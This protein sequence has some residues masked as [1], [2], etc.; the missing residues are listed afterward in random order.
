MKDTYQLPK[1]ITAIAIDDEPHVLEDLQAEIARQVPRL[2]LLKTFTN[3]RA[4]RRYLERHHVDVIICDVEFGFGNAVRTDGLRL[5]RDLATRHFF[6]F[7]SGHPEY[8]R[9]SLGLHA[10]GFLMK[11]L[12]A[13]ELNVKVDK[14]EN[15]RRNGGV[16][17]D[18]LAKLHVIDAET[19]ATE[20]VLLKDI[21]RLVTDPKLVNRSRVVTAK[22]DIPTRK[23][24][25]TLKKE[26]I[27][28][29]LFIVLSHSV[30]VA[31]VAIQRIEG[32]LVHL[33]DGFC[34]VCSRRHLPALHEFTKGAAVGNRTVSAK[35]AAV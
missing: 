27:G 22:K 24:L 10:D 14:L 20:V 30:V 19:T 8:A 1:K 32:N 26:V 34:T 31:K 29:G 3:G 12:S 7:L 21:V 6:L 33:T 28:S 17:Y 15:L 2:Q 9:L 23:P 4:A 5:A 11:P 13:D 35:S 25:V 18:V 16:W